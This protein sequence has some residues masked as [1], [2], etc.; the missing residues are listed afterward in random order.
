MLTLKDLELKGYLLD[1]SSQSLSDAID[2]FSQS[3]KFR[4]RSGLNLLLTRLHFGIPLVN[5]TKDL[6]EALPMVVAIS[7]LTLH[8]RAELLQHEALSSKFGVVVTQ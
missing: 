7:H 8:L 5:K 4:A 6:I 3:I 1:A 2:C